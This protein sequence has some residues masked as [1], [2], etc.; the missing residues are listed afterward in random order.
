MKIGDSVLFFHN[1]KEFKDSNNNALIA[2]ATVTKAWIGNALNL[3]V[4]L[5]NWSSPQSPVRGSVNHAESLKQALNGTP[6]WA[7]R[8]EAE[9]W[10]LDLTNHYKLKEAFD[11][12][13]ATTDEKKEEQAPESNEEIPDNSNDQ[14]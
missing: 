12:E 9:A 3:N 8:E 1:V 4:L 13:M 7:T 6:F 11:A 2:P 10:G 14:S 5:D